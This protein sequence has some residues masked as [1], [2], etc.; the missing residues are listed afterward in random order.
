MLDIITTNVFADIISLFNL[1]F[2]YAFTIIMVANYGIFYDRLK[3]HNDK[4]NIC[5]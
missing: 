5:Y 2:N 1:V 4:L 3:L